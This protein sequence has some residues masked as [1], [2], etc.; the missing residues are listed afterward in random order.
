MKLIIRQKAIADVLLAVEWYKSISAK[1]KDDFL[2]ELKI[3]LERVEKNPAIGHSYLSKARIVWLDR[4]PYSIVYKELKE[5]QL[6]A[7]VGVFHIRKHPNAML[8]RL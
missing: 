6:V 4:F 2:D 7:V 8:K 3:S 5:K 1:L